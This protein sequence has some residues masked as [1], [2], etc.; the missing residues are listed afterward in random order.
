V[1]QSYDDIG[2]L[3]QIEAKNGQTLLSRY[4]YTLDRAGRRTGLEV[5]R[6]EAAT[7]ERRYAWQ[8]DGADRLVREEQEDLLGDGDT[9]HWHDLDPAGNILARENVTGT[10]P[11]VETFAAAPDAALYFILCAAPSAAQRDI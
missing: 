4:T 10:A 1:T 7:L 2:R 6:G 8:Y 11:V 3:T 9:H 5:R